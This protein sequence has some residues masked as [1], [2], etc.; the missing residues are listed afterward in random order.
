MEVSRLGRE[1]DVAATAEARRQRCGA[2]QTHSPTW[3]RGSGGNVIV[4]AGLTWAARKKPSH[5]CA[6]PVRW[7][8]WEETM[9]GSLREPPGLGTLGHVSATAKPRICRTSPVLGL[10]CALVAMEAKCRHRRSKSDPG[11]W[12]PLPGPAARPLRL[13]AGSARGRVPHKDSH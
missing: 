10:A 8:T 3:Q 2:C 7:Q 5:P 4:C 9:P 13:R 12:Q 6:C 11:G 1:R